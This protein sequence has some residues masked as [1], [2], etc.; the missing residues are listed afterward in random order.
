MP[1]K[2]TFDIRFIDVAG[3][4]HLLIDNASLTDRTLC[5]NPA[6]KVPSGPVSFPRDKFLALR[7]HPEVFCRICVGEAANAAGYLD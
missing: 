5:G 3:I 1:D 2:P 6:R 4:K 7:A